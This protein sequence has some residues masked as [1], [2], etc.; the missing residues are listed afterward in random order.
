MCDR[1]IKDEKGQTGPPIS[2]GGPP[3]I[4]DGCPLAEAWLRD[5]WPRFLGAKVGGFFEEYGPGVL[6]LRLDQMAPGARF[7]E[8]LIPFQ[9][10]PEA[11][12]RSSPGWPPEFTA[13][14]KRGGRNYAR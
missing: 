2:D 14:D 8:K 1:E 13:D 4:Q 12:L 7:G 5:V 3:P 6:F 10:M 11:A 9:Y